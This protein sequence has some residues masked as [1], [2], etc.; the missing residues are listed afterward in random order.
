[1]LDCCSDI[2]HKAEQVWLFFLQAAMVASPGRD[3]SAGCMCTLRRLFNDTC[4]RINIINDKRGANRLWR[5]EP[6]SNYPANTV[7]DFS[8]RYQGGPENGKELVPGEGKVDAPCRC[9]P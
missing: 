1:M 3:A 8:Y 9:R 2:D 4:E 5:Y 7:P 6:A